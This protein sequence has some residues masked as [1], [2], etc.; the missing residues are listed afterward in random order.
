MYSQLRINN[1]TYG[2]SKISKKMSWCNMRYIRRRK[3]EEG[4]NVGE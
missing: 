4:N 3:N 2:S 1:I